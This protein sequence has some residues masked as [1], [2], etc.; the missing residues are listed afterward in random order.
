MGREGVMR[1]AFT[2]IEVLVVI[3]VIGVLIAIIAPSLD[4]ARERALCTAS[5]SNMHQVCA[6]G[7]TYRNDQRDALPITLAYRRGGAA[8]DVSGPLE[9][10][11]AWSFAGANCD[12]WWAGQAFDVEAADRPLNA[13]LAGGSTFEAPDPPAT[14]GAGDPARAAAKVPVCRAP[15]DD[16]T[17][18]RTPPRSTPGVGV[19]QDV[20]TS[21]LLNTRWWGQLAG[22]AD[23]E[24]RMRA[25]HRRFTAADATD[26][27]RMVWVHD[28]SAGVLSAAGVGAGGRLEIE[29]AFDDVNQSV[30]GFIDG[31][32]DY[33]RVDPGQVSRADRSGSYTL[34]FSTLPPPP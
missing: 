23:A 24:E 25:A 29:N 21:Y 1:R 11:C 13:Y 22:I 12:A 26:P 5:R 33:L 10:L 9:G 34:I 2:L 3:A 8:S 18:Q 6:A 32:V 20:G 14:L 4:R 27:S 31:H 17:R 19:Q 15:A 16:P 28:Q 7:A 30:M